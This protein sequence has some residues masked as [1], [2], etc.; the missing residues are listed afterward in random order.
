MI[1]FSRTLA[2]FI[3]IFTPW[4]RIDARTAGIHGAAAMASGYRRI[5]EVGERR[6]SDIGRYVSKLFAL[7]AYFM[8]DWRQD[9]AV[10]FANS[11]G[12]RPIWGE[13]IEAEAYYR[14]NPRSFG[15][16]RQAVIIGKIQSA[17]QNG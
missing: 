17:D 12:L 2:I 10:P 14:D 11:L 9:F 15:A 5:G 8:R 6:M 1:G 13:I 4:P 7:P 3:F 16:D